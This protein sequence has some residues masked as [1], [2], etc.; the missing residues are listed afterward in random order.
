MKNTPKSSVRPSLLGAGLLLLASSVAQAADPA[1]ICESSKLGTSAKYAQCRLK[2]EAK[3]VKAG[4]S[5]DYS[6]CTLDKF[7]SAETKAGMGA[8]PTE[9][10]QTTV[11]DY[12]DDCTSTAALWL[13]GGGGLP[14]TCDSDLLACE[15]DLAT[16]QSTP[17]ARTLKTG[18]VGCWNG[19]TPTAC[20][21]TY[22]D[23]ELQVGV[24]RNFTDNGNGTLTDNA[25]GLMWEKLSD[26]G[27]IHDKDNTYTWANA[28]AVKIATLNA[29]NF[30]GHNDWRLPN[31]FELETTLDLHEA[32]PMV[33]AAFK[34]GCTPSCDN[35]SCSCTGSDRYYSSTTVET[36][37][38]DAWIVVMSNGDLDAG[39]KTNA[40]H[41]RA[42]RGT[43]DEESCSVLELAK[44]EADL[45]TCTSDCEAAV[46]PPL[47][48]GQTTSYGAGSDGD[49][50]KG[51]VRSFTDNGDGT[52]TDNV[53]G[54]MWEKK[55]DDGSIHDRD[56]TYS[57]GM[58]SPPYTMNGT[59]VTTFLADLNSGGGFA[60][61][62]DW[63]IPNLHELESLRNFATSNPAV[64]P[65]FN[66]SCTGG[67]TV[68]TCSCTRSGGHWSSTT[69]EASPGNAWFVD[70]NFG[71]T[72]LDFKTFGYYVR[73]VRAGS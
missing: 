7:G 49:L 12:L 63:R 54:L 10:D 58:T 47:R 66:D 62:T 50:E 65:A 69:F 45:A 29:N 73:A 6:K 52:I 14:D 41:V 38:S 3:A 13:G 9:A 70:F 21:S 72:Y 28:I 26:D 44:A 51:A 39:L 33:H 15:G 31:R 46:R 17:T 55:S 11:K 64:Y 35:I 43:T 34:G 19:G 40:R 16:C 25:T 61:H 22:Q 32:A 56:N 59:M 2:A 27:T 30:G 5:V 71:Y 20:G 48:T 68:T 1:V 24:G 18:Q 42:V 67:C 53:T 4:A 36:Q 37:D 8:C 60:G 57:W 23:G